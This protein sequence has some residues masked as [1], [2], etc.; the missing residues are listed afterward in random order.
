MLV[1]Q[2]VSRTMNK[3]I[4]HLIHDRLMAHAFD[5][6]KAELL[7]KEHQL[8]DALY[9]HTYSKELQELLAKVPNSFLCMNKQMGVSLRFCGKYFY[10]RMSE[11][12]PTNTNVFVCEADHPLITQ[13]TNCLDEH[14]ALQEERESASVQINAT[15]SQVKSFKRLWEIWP[16]SKS[17]LQDLEDTMKPKNQLIVP[18]QLNKILNLPKE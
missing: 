7:V 16:E 12:R 17:L 1:S 4:K 14:K 5:K 10:V 3:D 13:V 6:R 9:N 11:E 15:L 18:D 2:P 8:A